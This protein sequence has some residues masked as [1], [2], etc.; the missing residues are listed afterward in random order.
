M[1]KEKLI[2]V[3]ES[4]RENYVFFATE[5]KRLSEFYDVHFISTSGVEQA[6]DDGWKYYFYTEKIGKIKKFFYL[7]KYF[8]DNRCRTEYKRICKDI[9]IFSGQFFT[10][11][12]KS[13]EYYASAEEFYKFLKRNIIGESKDFLY[14]TYWCN[15]YALSM[16][17]HKNEYKEARFVSRLHRFDIY[18][19]QFPG[20]IQPFKPYINSV[21]DRLLFVSELSLKYYLS[22]HD[23]VDSSKV[24]LNRLGTVPLV[25]SKKDSKDSFVLASCSNLLPVKRVHL[26]V[27]ALAQIDGIEIHWIHFGGGP[28]MT[29]IDR[30]VHSLLDEKDNITYTLM[31]AVDNSEIRSYYSKNQIDAFINVSESEGAP[32]SIM[33]A[34]SARIP[35][36]ATAVG[37]A[38]IMCEDNGILLQADPSIE[39]IASAIVEISSLP[40]EEREKMCDTSYRRWTELFNLDTNIS[41]L[42]SE[43][44]KLG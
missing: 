19:D 28:C 32:V 31:G 21:V 33:E 29:D 41:S 43:F 7:F 12:I 18:D 39:E 20:G 17:L 14:Y 38:E 40:S 2:F 26:I 34:M 25:N 4:Y 5:L 1:D 11:V 35:I 30:L 16:S 8:V 9:K 24:M 44:R 36:I 27:K 42:I 10:R 6:N 22:V 23:D 37:E 15:Y 3:T 13:V